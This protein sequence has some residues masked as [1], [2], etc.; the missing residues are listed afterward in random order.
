[1]LLHTHSRF[2]K[3]PSELELLAA[4]N[5]LL[6]A[7]A[8]RLRAEHAAAVADVDSMRSALATADEQISM[9]VAC[10]HSRVAL[11]PPALPP[12]PS[13]VHS[14][15]TRLSLHSPAS[16]APMGA[17]GRRRRHTRILLSRSLRRNS[18]RGRVL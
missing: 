7:T 15:L 13:P 11:F 5:A 6:G 17:L 18:M 9:L 1:M 4:E 2:L 3:M 14:R 16:G 12:P 10:A 8:Q